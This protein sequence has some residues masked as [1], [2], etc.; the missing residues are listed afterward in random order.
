MSES[1]KFWIEHTVSGCI[2]T[3]S[4]IFLMLSFNN[5]LFNNLPKELLPYLFI[6]FIAFS[7]II[8]YSAQLIF[9]NI[10]HLILKEFKYNSKREFAII[11]NNPSHIINIYY[12]VYIVLILFRHLILGTTIL[13]GSLYIWLGSIKK[14]EYRCILSLIS[15]SLILLFII[16]YILQRNGF[17]ELKKIVKNTP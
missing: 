10:I 7:S 8:G 11:Q 3:T 14:T 1:I 4:I 12:K 5:D 16:V 2:Y 15:I 9:S 17:N 13:W 6:F